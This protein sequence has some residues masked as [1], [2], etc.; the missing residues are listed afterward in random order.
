[1]KSTFTGFYNPS[2][3]EINQA[4]KEDTTLFVFDTN[5]LLYLYSYAKNTKNDFFQ[6]LEKISNNIW[7]PYHVGLEYQ[8]NRLKIVKNEKY[9]FSKIE[10]YL[11]DI[12]NIFT[13]NIKDLNLEQRHPKLNDSTDKLHS[14]IN[15]AIKKYKKSLVTWDKKQPC[16]MSSDE[17][18]KKINI[19]FDNKIG[20]KPNNQEWLQQIYN[21]G[22]DRYENKVPPGYEDKKEKEKYPSFV[23]SDLKY[24]PMY[25]DL[26]IWNQIID[27]AKDE[28]IKSVIF[29][30]DDVKEDWLYSIDVKGKKEIGARAELRDEIYQKSNINLF[31]IL[32]TSDFMKDGKL[33]LNI[34]VSDES[35]NETKINF[36][37]KQ[38]KYN[39]K[40]HENLLKQFEELNSNNS[41]SYNDLIQDQIKD[42]EREK[43]LTLNNKW[44]DIFDDNRNTFTSKI[45]QEELDEFKKPNMESLYLEIMKGI[46]QEK[47]LKEETAIERVLKELKKYK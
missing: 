32:T 36:E 31:T 39:L 11:N 25:G 41:V 15:V 22:K 43:K 8:R 14:E 35:I 2:E 33:N 44:L 17:I 18:R 46:E 26:I 21:D 20:E 47:T 24:I 30:S 45:L 12:D 28:N 27:K 23:Y 16:V 7:L 10:K 38:I 13:K 34:D 9:N 42:I 1:M 3:E 19:L 37:N 29:I 5:V 6:I 4:W 40:L